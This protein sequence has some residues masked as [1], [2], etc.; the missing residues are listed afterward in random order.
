MHE[1]QNLPDQGIFPRHQG[2]A[3]C[4]DDGV[5]LHYQWINKWLWPIDRFNIWVFNPR[6]YLVPVSTGRNLL[7]LHSPHGVLI[8]S[9]PQYSDHPPDP[10]L[11]S[12]ISRLRIDL[13]EL[14]APPRCRTSGRL[15]DRWILRPGRESDN[16][17]RDEQRGWADQEMLHGG[18]NIRGILRREYRWPAIDK[19]AD[20]V[21]ALSR[22]LAW[23]NHMVNTPTP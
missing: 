21:Q 16:H 6:L 17:D 19:I 11:L 10:L 9:H 5:G 3:G 22:A 18:D 2:L 12:R 7:H 15:L 8:V 23:S 14:V 20:Q 4:F 13:E 1:V